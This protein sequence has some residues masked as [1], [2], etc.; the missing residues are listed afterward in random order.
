MVELNPPRDRLVNVCVKGSHDWLFGDLR[1][2][3]GATQLPGVSVLAS[4]EPVSDADGWIFI[5]TGE[6]GS[7]PDL[8][9]TVVCL[10]DLY[11]HNGMY[12]PQGQRGAVHRAGALVLCHPHQRDILASAGVALDR[13][14][15]LERPLGALQ[16]FTVRD[17]RSEPFTVGWVGRD[18]WR[19]RLEFLVEAVERFRDLCPTVRVVLIGKELDSLHARISA[20]GIE[21]VLHDRHNT[22]IADYPRLYEA[23]E[24]L[25]ITSCTEAGPLP[26]F[27][28]LATGVPVVSTPVGWAPHFAAIEPAF[29]RLGDTPAELA[30]GLADV[31]RSAPE[32]FEAR[33]RIAA[34]AAS[35]RLDSWFA[36]T[37]QLAA[38]LLDRERIGKPTGSYPSLV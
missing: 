13:K 37:L 5:R 7:S 9:R 25:L 28:S 32:L 21:C 30:H 1:A 35:P 26:L 10:H 2:R 15:L 16:A 3:F 23:L 36:E 22:S 8:S 33:S 29:V 18:H 27:E 11:S 31:W 19:K 20:A 34:L 4:E 17:R 14:L 24:C 6:A 12:S 38:K